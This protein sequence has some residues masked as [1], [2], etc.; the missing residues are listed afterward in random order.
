MT[1]P[2]DTAY[3]Q[4]VNAFG[5]VFVI[6]FLLFIVVNGMLAFHTTDYVYSE[7]AYEEAIAKPNAPYTSYIP[8]TGTQFMP[9]MGI[10]GGG[11][12]FHNMSLPMVH[13]AEN[14]ENNTRDLGI[15][16]F[17]GFLTYSIVGLAGVYG[18]TG[19]AFASHTPYDSRIE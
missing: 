14:P 11:F 3:I 2:R 12:V 8:L 6:I 7:Q 9:L 5:V 4:K 17:L 10:L 1:A 16:F 19:A 18:F 15:G 13:Y